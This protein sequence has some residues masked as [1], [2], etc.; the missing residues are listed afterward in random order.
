M[1]QPVADDMEHSKEGKVLHPD[2][3]NETV[4]RTQYAVRGELYLRAQQL[5][6]EG[7]SIT[8]TNVGNPHQ[9]GQKPITF[10]RQVLALCSAPFLMDDPKVL[11]LF[12]Q[13][14]VDR[15][16]QLHAYLNG[17][18]GAYSDSKGAPGIRQEIAD[19]IQRRDGHAAN[20]DNIF[21][22]DGASVGVRMCL[23]SLIR[24]DRDAVLVPVPQYPLYSASI[25][26]Y[27]GSFTG[28]YL[29]EESG[30]SMDMHNLQETVDK[31]K[32]AGKMVRGLVFINPGNPTG[33]CLTEAN[34]QDL[35]KFA[36]KN[37]IVLM[38]DEVY[39]PNIYQDEKPFVSARK[40]A[41]DM[42]EPYAS[43]LEL[44]SFHTVS[45]GVLG[46]CGL[47][48]GY[49]EALNL[50]PGTLAELYKM[51]SINLCPNTAGQVMVGL[52]VN[53]PKAGSA[54]QR[55]VA[56]EKAALEASL[57]RKAHLVTDFFNGLEGVTCQFTEGAMYSFPRIQLPPKAIKAA[58]ASGKPQDFFYCLKLLEATGISTVPGSGF[59]QQPGTFHLR[60]TILAMEEDMP[61]ILGKWR[62]FHEEF[63]AKYT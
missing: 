51:A 5:Q 34:L 20:P 19:F 60:T 62:K 29:N 7:M 48:G 21:M 47:R 43:A 52:M 45:K 28:Y 46:E 61:E 36:V 4:K 37:Q 11:E 32:A 33:Q 1:P 54:A 57:R 22:T 53:E 24:D 18:V 3:L 55:Q 2:L 10:N 56:D 40:V 16:R 35:I 26:L 31:A 42:G 13:E 38:A 39:Q 17:G 27:N 58:E 15:A 14:A 25:A 49:F 41:L 23:N 59:G 50:H 6:K 44:I 12:P 30:W 9:L 8:Y 63:M